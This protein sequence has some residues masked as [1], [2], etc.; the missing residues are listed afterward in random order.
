MTAREAVETPSVHA[1]KDSLLEQCG[2]SLC[3]IIYIIL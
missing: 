1:F 3:I 2:C